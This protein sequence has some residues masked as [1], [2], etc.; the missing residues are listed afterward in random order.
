[1]DRVGDGYRDDDDRQ[2]VGDRVPASTAFAV[3]NLGE[4]L[5]GAWALRRLLGAPRRF[6]RLPEIVALALV[7]VLVSAPVVM[8]IAGCASGKRRSRACRGRW[9]KLPRGGNRDRHVLFDRNVCPAAAR[10]YSPGTSCAL[11]V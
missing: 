4:P 2:G 6:T 7:A 9:R 3:A 11:P 5:V 1:M 10:G 8:P